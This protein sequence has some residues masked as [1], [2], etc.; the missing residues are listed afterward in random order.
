[1]IKRIVLSLAILSVALFGGVVA[2]PATAAAQGANVQTCS[3]SVL[4]LPAWYKYL[5]LDG[6]C[7]VVGPTNDSGAFDWSL[8]AGYIALAIFEVLLRLGAVVAVFF[9]MYGGF[10]FITS[11][12]EPENA[13]SARQTIINAIIGLVITIASASIVS[14]VATRL[15][16]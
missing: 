8:A 10:R 3:R 9:V 1:M 14:F 6:S 4:G 11:Q 12:G 15:T 7:D 5:D 2:L 16:S 13:A